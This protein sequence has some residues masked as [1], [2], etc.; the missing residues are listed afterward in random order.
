MPRRCHPTG[1]L[2]TEISQTG[3]YHVLRQKLANRYHFYGSNCLRAGRSK[4]RQKLRTCVQAI[5]ASLILPR[6][7]KTPP[8]ARLEAL[9]RLEGAFVRD[10]PTT[11]RA[12]VI[13]LV[14]GQ[15]QTSSKAKSSASQLSISDSSSSRKSSGV[16]SSGPSKPYRENTCFVG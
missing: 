11:Y 3:D 1:K 16:P 14:R 2:S 12:A 10:G 6:R 15:R 13:A 7:K 9:R 8:F 5:G 4:R